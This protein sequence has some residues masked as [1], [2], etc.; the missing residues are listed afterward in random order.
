MFELKST[1]R[2]NPKTVQFFNEEDGVVVIRASEGPSFI[3]DRVI[4]GVSRTELREALAR[5]FGWTIY[6]NADL[7]EVTAHPRDRKYVVVEGFNF[8]LDPEYSEY[9]R[10]KIRQYMAVENYI[11]A[12]PP[13]KDPADDIASI[14]WEAS[15]AD[16]GS[17][18]AM[19]AK[20]IANALI[21]SG[22]VV[23]Q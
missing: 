1:A 21:N 22:K 20:V 5:E 12:H 7:P 2:G 15:R 11:D 17:I 13:V 3:S 18:S 19:G 4:V 6:D 10:E 8:T 9:R 14:I 16:E 23:A